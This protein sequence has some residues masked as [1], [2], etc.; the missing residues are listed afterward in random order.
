MK[1]LFKRLM[2]VAIFAL[3]SLGLAKDIGA[4]EPVPTN[5]GNIQRLD[6][7][8]CELTLIAGALPTRTGHVYTCSQKFPCSDGREYVLMYKLNLYGEERTTHAD[9]ICS[10]EYSK[11][12][13]SCIA[14]PQSA[15]VN[16]CWNEAVDKK[17]LKDV[18]KFTEGGPAVSC[19]PPGGAKG[20]YIT[21]DKD[22]GLFNYIS[23]NVTA[24]EAEIYKEDRMVVVPYQS[25]LGCTLILQSVNSLATKLM[26]RFSPGSDSG[27]LQPVAGSSEPVP[28][29]TCTMKSDARDQFCPGTKIAPPPMLKTTTSPESA[30]EATAT[31]A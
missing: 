2:T 14:E 15:A 24:N 30:V 28:A 20:R 29:L 7:D 11:S 4:P 21:L 18:E 5:K 19:S 12:E 31:G 6:T 16:A 22:G 17:I 3:P 8:K 27:K 1:K 23:G 25:A 9:T 26:I 10:A 13:E